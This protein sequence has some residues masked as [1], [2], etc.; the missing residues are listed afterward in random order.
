MS[1]KIKINSVSLLPFNS[2]GS[3]EPATWHPSS[4]PQPGGGCDSLSLRMN[5]APCT[6]D[7]E[8]KPAYSDGKQVA[9]SDLHLSCA[10]V[11]GARATR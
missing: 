6:Q 3:A 8:A 10:E 7:P 2:S 4:G 1:F 5:G 9:A 11:R